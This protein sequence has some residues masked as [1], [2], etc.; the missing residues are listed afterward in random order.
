MRSHLADITVLNAHIEQSSIPKLLN[1]ELPLDNVPLLLFIRIGRR[2]EDS[3]QKRGN[4]AS[5]NDVRKIFGFFDPLPPLSAN[6][7]NLPY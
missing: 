2:G 6:L 3:A 5:I 4:G 1:G 7:C